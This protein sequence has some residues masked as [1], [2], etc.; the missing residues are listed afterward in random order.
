MRGNGQVLVFP[1]AMGTRV[2]AH[3]GTG[4][5]GH[6]ARSRPVRGPFEARSSLIFSHGTYVLPGKNRRSEVSAGAHAAVLHNR[7]ASHL[8]KPE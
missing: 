1:Q 4:Q 2:V 7:L 8:R 3:V 6:H 5:S